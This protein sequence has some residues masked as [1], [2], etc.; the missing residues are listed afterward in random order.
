MQ[1]YNEN[2]KCLVI[3]KYR[4][5]CVYNIFEALTANFKFLEKLQVKIWTSDPL[6]SYL[7][8][9]AVG[10]KTQILRQEGSIFP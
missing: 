5:G 3:L 1:I 8:V 4:C 7:L 2:I 6:S 9:L 10:V